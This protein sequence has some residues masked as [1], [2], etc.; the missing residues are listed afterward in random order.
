MMTP[1]QTKMSASRATNAAK[2]GPRVGKSVPKPKGIFGKI[3]EKFGKAGKWIKQLG[4]RFI[5]PLVT[6]PYGW[7]ILGGL[8]LGGLAY[9][10][11][12]EVK[13]AWNKVTNF[14]SETFSKISEF[15]SSLAGNARTM[16]GDFLRSVGAGM[17]ADWIDP[18]GADKKEK[19]KE[20]TWKNFGLELYNIYTGLWK[21]V[22]G[23]VQKG[24]KAV[25][26]IAANF[27]EK[28]GM[29][30]SLVSWIRGKEEEVIPEGQVTAT[31]T[32]AKTKDEKARVKSNLAT[33]DKLQE[34]GGIFGM[35]DKGVDSKTQEAIEEIDTDDLRMAVSGAKHNGLDKKDPAL[36][37]AMTEELEKRTMS[38]DDKEDTIMTKGEWTASDE[39]KKTFL[40]PETNKIEGASTEVQ[41][42]EYTKYVEGKRSTASADLSGETAERLPPTVKTPPRKDFKT[43]IGG[44][45]AITSFREWKS[46]KGGSRAEKSEAAENKKEVITN[47]VD[48]LKD[49]SPS[50]LEATV[51]KMEPKDL[52]TLRVS[53]LASSLEGKH[54]AFPVRGGAEYDESGGGPA[55]AA[56]ISAKIKK[57]E[58][59]FKKGGHPAVAKL[60]AAHITPLVS[61]DAKTA[62]LNNIH[63]ENAQLKDQQGSAA[64]MVNA[65]VSSSVTNN[66]GSNII[67]ASN[68]AQGGMDL[69]NVM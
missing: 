2:V 6:N 7:A 23:I 37:K 11:W 16:L 12:D 14:V 60:R 30:D 42:M 65:P 41:E 44:M 55:D 58:A 47:L 46:M 68:T 66:S 29:P 24:F 25:R 53:G 5:M 4:S 9:A 62:G 52:T 67:L 35:R 63:S 32:V 15:A 45:D 54:P 48:K 8:A 31:E 39:F 20:F 28:M 19:K 61:P 34:E 3:V 17:I 43:P 69:S 1:E 59:A 10:Y 21:E 40:N 26:G 36:V 56:A 18:D 33:L 38:A 64:T 57:E 13:A 22:L 49:M 51:A 27:A 50:E